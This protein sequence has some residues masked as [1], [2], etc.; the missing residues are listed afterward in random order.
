MT[1]GVLLQRFD[2]AGGIVGQ[3]GKGMDPSKADCGVLAAEFV[4]GG[5]EA[6]GEQTSG[7]AFGGVFGP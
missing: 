4:A 7:V 2:T 5:V 6:F 1:A 3:V